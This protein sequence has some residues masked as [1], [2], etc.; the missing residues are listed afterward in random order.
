[1]G[2]ESS[3]Y[4]IHATINLLPLSY[5]AVVNEIAILIKPVFQTRRSQEKKIASIVWIIARTF[6][7]FAGLIDASHEDSRKVGLEGAIL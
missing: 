3:S 7:C 5:E 4:C 2:Y 6:L 1:V